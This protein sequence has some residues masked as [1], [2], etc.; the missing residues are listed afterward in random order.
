M[1]VKNKHLLDTKGPLF[2]I[3]NHPNS[4]L[5][6]IIIGAYYN[7]TV[8]FLARGDV[9]EKKIYRFFLN[10]LNMIPVYRIRDGINSVEKNIAV[11]EQCFEILKKEKAIQIFAEGEH[12]Q[13]RRIIPLK[14]GFA[15]IILGTLQKY[16]DLNINLMD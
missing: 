15:R 8:F 6:A 16:P 5:D 3:A 12:H 2:I 14:K 1:H 11:F 4:F 9:F 13:Y 7:R 10:A